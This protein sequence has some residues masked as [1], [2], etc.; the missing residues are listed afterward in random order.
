MEGLLE[1]LRLD[2]GL[3]RANREARVRPT[4]S[5]WRTS[6]LVPVSVDRIDSQAILTPLKWFDSTLAKLI[7]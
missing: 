5:Q 4:I 3:T 1:A 7:S 2:P 6:Y